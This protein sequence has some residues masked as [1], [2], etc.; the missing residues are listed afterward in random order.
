MAN[1]S[2]YS[3]ILLYW[4]CRRTRLYIN[5]MNYYGK[6]YNTLLMGCVL[7]VSAGIIQYDTIS[8]ELS[9]T[10]QGLHTRSCG[11]GRES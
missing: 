1:T 7:T 5:V 4:T 3:T 11:G 6:Q 2:T 9:V 10:L 8:V